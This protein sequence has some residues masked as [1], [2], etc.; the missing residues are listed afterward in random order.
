MDMIREGNRSGIESHSRDGLLVTSQWRQAFEGNRH[1]VYAIA[2]WMTGSELAAEGVM[3]DV[4]RAALSRDAAATTQD[5]D[6]ALLE[7]LRELFDIPVFT[8]HCVP[9]NEVRNVRLSVLRTDLECA[10]LQLPAT[11]KLIFLLHDVEGYDHDSIAR[12]VGV[13]ERESRLGL[14]QARLRLRELLSQQS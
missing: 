11:E 7:E 4:F 2:F 1:R 12:L 9:N 10:V 3:T 5:I 13:T 6:R 8:L 14:H